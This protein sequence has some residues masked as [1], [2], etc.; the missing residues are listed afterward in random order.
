[1]VSTQDTDASSPKLEAKVH[2]VSLP[3]E[4]ATETQLSWQT[5]SGRLG[6]DWILDCDYKTRRERERVSE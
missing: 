4:L 2:S 5:I 6:I 1:M 3:N